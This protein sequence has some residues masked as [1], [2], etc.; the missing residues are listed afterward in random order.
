MSKS[1][2]IAKRQQVM[3]EDFVD[4]AM[5]NTNAFNQDLQDWINEHA[6]GSTW[7]RGGLDDK[8]RSLV[9]IAMFIA[10]KTPTE[11]KGHIRGAMNNGASVNEIK[12]VLLHSILYCGAPA[13]QEAFRTAL[14][15]FAEMGID[16]EKI[17]DKN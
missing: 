12:E 9:T 7:Q 3:G 2:G 15:V 4:K 6:W 13:T 10:L 16:I 1:D 5:H 14:A 17:S 8:T 11:L